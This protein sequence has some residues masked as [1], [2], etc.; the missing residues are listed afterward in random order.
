MPHDTKI[1][2]DRLR[3]PVERRCEF[4]R[5]DVIAADSDRCQ[6]A[7]CV[8]MVHLHPL[9][10][11]D[12]ESLFGATGLHARATA[13]GPI[14]TSARNHF[15][16]V[17]GIAVQPLHPAGLTLQ[18]EEPGAMSAVTCEFSIRQRSSCS[19]V[20]EG[21]ALPERACRRRRPSSSEP[22][23]LSTS[24]IRCVMQRGRFVNHRR[25]SDGAAEGQ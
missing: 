7:S 4:Q 6:R 25:R 24:Q 1:L 15:G 8:P 2:A 21:T 3:A 19:E 17:R 18:P 13:H 23:W 14:R 9:P 5:G 11:S 10:C 12:G 20:V 22:S 16:P